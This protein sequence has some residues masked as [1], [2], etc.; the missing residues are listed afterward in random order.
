LTAAPEAIVD[1]A[2]NEWGTSGG[3]FPQ[4]VRIAYVEALRDRVQAHAICEEY[5]AG[6]TI[7]REHDK[8]IVRVG[9]TSLARYW[10]Y[11]APADPLRLGSWMKAGPFRSRLDWASDVR[12]HPLDA[13][14][15]F[16]EEKPEETAEALGH[17][18]AGPG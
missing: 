4:E 9:G 13:G 17:F 8:A 14:H 15:S 12:G 10:F 11:G 3:A 5:R 18:F 16:P 7:D 2:P 6:A 1:H